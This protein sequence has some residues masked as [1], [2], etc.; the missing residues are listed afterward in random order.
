MTRILHIKR[1]SWVLL[2]FVTL[3]AVLFG[4]GYL[5]RPASANSIIVNSLANDDDGSNCTLREAI[6]AANSNTSVGGCAAG[7]GND[8]ITFSVTGTINL[9]TELDNILG[10]LRIE[11]PG[12]NSLT[13]RRSGGANFRIF[14]IG[15]YG[16]NNAYTVYLGGMTISNGR[17]PEGGGIANLYGNLTIENAVISSNA[18]TGDGGGGIY[19][20][21]LSDA[22][23]NNLIISNTTFVGNTATP[24]GSQQDKG[25]G[26]IRNDKSNVSIYSSVITGNVGQYGGGW[27][28]VSGTVTVSQVLFENNRTQGYR[29]RAGAFFHGDNDNGRTTIKDSV[30]RGNSTSNDPSGEGSGIAGALF[31]QRGLIEI[32][33]TT[34]SGNRAFLDG[35]AIYKSNDGPM[36]LYNVT[37]SDNFAG[38]GNSTGGGIYAQGDYINIVNSTIVYNKGSDGGGIY[39][40][41]FAPEKPQAFLRHTIVAFN[42]NGS[43]NPNDVNGEIASRGWNLVKNRGGATG[44]IAEDLPVSAALTLSPLQNNGGFVFTHLPLPGSTVIDAGDPTLGCV[45]HTNGVQNGGNPN[46]ALTFDARNFPRPGTPGTRCDIGAVE[47]ANGLLVTNPNDNG[48]TSPSGIGTLSYAIALANDPNRPANE[49]TVTFAASVTTVTLSTGVTLPSVANGVT[50]QGRC[51]GTGAGVV[52]DGGGNNP[53]ASSA[54]VVLNGGATLSGVRIRNF[55]GRELLA[56]AL[57]GK[58]ILTCVRVG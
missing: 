5:A 8:V 51:G 56:R 18:A 35:G 17:L 58:N 10:N 6:Q 28:K 40:S 50:V 43:G 45:K 9:T 29:N 23:M 27:F 33:N 39:L 3:A 24:G 7:G 36:N 21:G 30:F 46:G 32:Y 57:N 22:N 44:F 52:I 41:S 2:T 38:N 13:V 49:R 31:T 26:A 14:T 42:T 4:A 19:T 54:G 15:D 25:G 34:F 12:A 11:G 1:P 20:E 37:I 53:G 55:N 16:N 48:D 47:I